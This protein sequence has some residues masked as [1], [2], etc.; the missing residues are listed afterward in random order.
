MD[1]IELQAALMVILH[2]RAT[3]STYAAA[4]II[5]DLLSLSL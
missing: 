1:T 3:L 4:L 5:S 2:T